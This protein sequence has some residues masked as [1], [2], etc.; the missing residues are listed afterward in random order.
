[1]REST[2][3]KQGGWGA[4]SPFAQAVGAALRA[5]RRQ[6]HWSQ[7]DLAGHFSTAFVS[8]VEAGDAVP[9]LPALAYLLRRLD[10]SLG[11]FFDRVSQERLAPNEEAVR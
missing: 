7:R 5:E 2:I 10:L 6:R 3:S 8:R 9:S 4:G 11:E 1:M